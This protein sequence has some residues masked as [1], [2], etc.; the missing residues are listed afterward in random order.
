MSCLYYNHSFF[1]H[2]YE[3]EDEKASFTNTLTLLFN[4][5]ESVV[6]WRLFF[7]EDFL[8]QRIWSDIY[9]WLEGF[10]IL[11]YWLGDYLKAIFTKQG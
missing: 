9:L 7:C 8:I 1:L 3:L 10:F 2:L 5:S 4:D 11:F 6:A